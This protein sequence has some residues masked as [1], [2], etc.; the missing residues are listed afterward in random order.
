MFLR[1]NSSPVW[2]PYFRITPEDC[3]GIV[4]YESFVEL[5]NPYR[6]SGPTL[7]ASLARPDNPLGRL[8]LSIA[9]ELAVA[10]Q[11]ADTLTQEQKD[12]IWQNLSAA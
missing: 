11:A 5:T 10:C 9:R 12:V 3:P 2:Q 7:R 4:E 6:P 8:G 1:I